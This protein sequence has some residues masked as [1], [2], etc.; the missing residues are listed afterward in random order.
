LA[1]VARP[2]GFFTVHSGEVFIT[3]LIFNLIFRHPEK[4]DFSRE[5]HVPDLLRYFRSI[6]INEVIDRSL[7]IPPELK[8]RRT[9]KVL[10]WRGEL[11]SGVDQFKLVSGR[12]LCFIQ[13]YEFEVGQFRT[14]PA[15]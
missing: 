7:I 15:F 8:K 2:G 13:P 5:L 14:I 10:N 1:Y 6:N 9:E 12:D 11:Y 3:S 4:I